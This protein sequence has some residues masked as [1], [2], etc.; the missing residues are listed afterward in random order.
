MNVARDSSARRLVFREIEFNL[1]SFSV[2]FDLIRL[3]VLI[4]EN[5]QKLR[6]MRRWNRKSGWHVTR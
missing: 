1:C 6:G 5:G 3:L 2:S 4:R